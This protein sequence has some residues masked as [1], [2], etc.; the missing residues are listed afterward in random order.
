MSLRDRDD[1]PGLVD[2]VYEAALDEG[3]WPRLLERLAQAFNSASAHLS[4]ENRQATQGRLLSFGIDPEYGRRYGEYYVSRNVL[5]QRTVERSL[6]GIL[7]NRSIMPQEELERSEFY[8][9]FLH[10]QGGDEL[11]ISLASQQADFA[12]IVTLWRP[13][14]GGPW[15]AKEMKML[16][17]L[18]PHLRRALKVNHHLGDLRVLQE[19]ASEALYRLDCGVML[20]DAEA[21]LI[22]ANNAA[23]ATFAERGGLRLERGRLAAP[24][25][26]DTAALRRLI[27]G[28]AQGTGGSFVVARET[29]PSLLVVA[30]PFKE[31]RNGHPCQGPKAILFIKDLKRPE[32]RSLAA[33]SEYFGLTAAQASLARELMKGDGVTAAA[34]R[35]GISRATARTHLMHIFQKTA[36]GRQAELVRLMLEWSEAPVA[37]S[38]PSG[39]KGARGGGSRPEAG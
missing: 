8:N 16:A 23:E 38:G 35:L 18:T 17:A 27:A 3:R 15:Q 6:Q 30:T 26:S 20:V 10:P 2:D 24:Q 1:L 14:R 39:R 32:T 33:F 5:W 7:T 4:V 34:T 25:G 37:A 9:D 21:Q 22:F 31:A 11:L 36:T 12:S 19:F 13:R 28:A 29:R